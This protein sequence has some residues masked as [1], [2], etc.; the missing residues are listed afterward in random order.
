MSDESLNFKRH[1]R[2]RLGRYEVE[3]ISNNVNANDDDIQNK[4]LINFKITNVSAV[5]KLGTK[6]NLKDISLRGHDMELIQDRIVS[7]SSIIS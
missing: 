3:N 5:M 6:L 1:K 4:K 7:Y 2:V